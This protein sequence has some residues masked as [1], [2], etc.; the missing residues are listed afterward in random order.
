[1]SCAV[2]L[3]HGSDLALLWLWRRPAAI[4]LIQPLAWEP[5]YAVSEALK[6]QKITKI[7]SGCDDGY[8]TINIINSLSS[9]KKSKTETLESK[10]MKITYYVTRELL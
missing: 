1:M 2:D 7:K 8:T 9:K 4:A 3:G 10:K 5:P 6:R